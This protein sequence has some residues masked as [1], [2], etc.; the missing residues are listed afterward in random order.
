M[1]ILLNNRPLKGDWKLVLLKLMLGKVCRF[2][3]HK[4]FTKYGGFN[5]LI[6]IL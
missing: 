4:M 1:L 5:L 2:K 3:E 6:W